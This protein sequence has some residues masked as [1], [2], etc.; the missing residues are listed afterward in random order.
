MLTALLAAQ[1][2]EE[3]GIPA[4]LWQVVAGPGPEIGGALVGAADYVCFTGSTATGRLIARQCAD[5]LIGCSLELGGKN[6]ML[7]LRDADVNRR[8][9]APYAPSSPTPASSASRWSASSS[10]TRSMT[11]SSSASSPAPRR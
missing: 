2:L 8:Q 11:A 9:R 4:D 6:P 5:R 3:A 10:P 7:V 1:L